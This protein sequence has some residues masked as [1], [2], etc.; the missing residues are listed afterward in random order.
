MINLLWPPQTIKLKNLGHT[1][2]GTFQEIVYLANYQDQAIQSA[3][4]Q[5]KYQADQS[6][7][8]LLGTY[9]D[10]YL[11]QLPPDFII[12]PMPVSYNRW[13]ERGYNHIELIVNNSHYR[14][15]VRSDILQKTTH[16]K[17]QTQVPRAQRV[18]QQ[19]DTFTVSAQRA[20]TLGTTVILLDDVVTT[21]STMQA[22]KAALEPTLSTHTNLICVAIAH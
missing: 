8:Q 22:A 13:R 14:K 5:N 6:A 9:L 15:K 3:I 16:T 17:Q 11:Q 12:I 7:A 10:Q 4:K 20:N 2:V 21:G 19:R 1:K 18:S